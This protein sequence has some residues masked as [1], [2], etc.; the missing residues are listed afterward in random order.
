L[1]VGNPANTNAFI[2]S[3][4]A[5]SIPKEQFSALTRLDHNRAHAQLAKKLGVGLEQISG[6]VIWGN[7]S[8][9]QVPDVTHVKVNGEPVDIRSKLGNEY[10]DGTYVPL[11][12]CRGA[13]VIAAR[14]LSSAL[15]AAKAI[16]DQLY[17]WLQGASSEGFVSMA[18]VSDGSYGSPSGTFFSFPCQC[19]NG[20]WEIVQGLCL[21]EETK[22]MIVKTSEELIAERDEAL[23]CLINSPDLKSI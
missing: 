6:M 11:I 19:S 8:N 15:S 5:K 17:S 14:K 12:Q 2:V 3:H 18:V 16:A 4:Y 9:T 21:S 7:H 22:Q 23:L 13:S 20:K 10:I 1:V